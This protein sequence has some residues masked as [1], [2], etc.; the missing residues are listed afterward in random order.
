MISSGE[1]LVCTSGNS[2]FKEGS[3]YTVGSIV[4][5]EL[6]E[7]QVGANDEYWY[8]TKENKGICI[9]FESKEYGMGNAWFSRLK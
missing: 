8:A 6:F 5:S 3:I 9:R 7:V 4:T 2:F 1:K